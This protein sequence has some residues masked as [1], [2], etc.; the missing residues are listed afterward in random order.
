VEYLTYSLEQLSLFFSQL[1]TF[2]FKKRV[3]SYSS[4]ETDF[5]C[6]V[7]NRALMSSSHIWKIGFYTNICI[8]CNN[9]ADNSKEISINELLM[10]NDIQSM[11][12]DFNKNY[13]Y[14][15]IANHIRE[16]LRHVENHYFCSVSC[17]LTCL[18]L[19]TEVKTYILVRLNEF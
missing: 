12:Y 5:L 9:Y 16:T 18:K 14:S 6:N 4:Q 7:I 3:P 11:P 19:P 15:T 13:D 1:Y 8:T 2:L 10:Y 17:L